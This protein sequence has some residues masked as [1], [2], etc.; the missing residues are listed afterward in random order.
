MM[1]YYYPQVSGYRWNMLQRLKK[2][3]GREPVSSG[4]IQMSGVWMTFLR[5]NPPLSAGEESLV[6]AVMAD[7]P[8]YPPSTF[9][10]RF[11]IDD[12]WE[13]LG[14]F[15]AATG[16]QFDLYFNESVPG[17]GV[18]DLLE[19]HSPSPLTNQQRNQVKS[20]FASIIKDV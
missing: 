16:I 4:D 7:N 18:V 2:A 11:R 15:R 20:A 10:A 13:R 12:L 6:A 3:V 14:D 5:F 19:L 17:S 8:C 1:E 9:G